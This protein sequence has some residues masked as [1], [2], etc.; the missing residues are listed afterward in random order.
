MVLLLLLVVLLFSLYFGACR[1][2]GVAQ[3]AAHTLAVH[4][5]DMPEMT[6]VLLREEPGAIKP[7]WALFC[8]GVGLLARLMGFF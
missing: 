2:R 5:A 8:F 6:G 7:R 1:V 4:V 3:A